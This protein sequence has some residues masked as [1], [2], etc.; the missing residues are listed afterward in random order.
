M[1]FITGAKV[2]AQN[3][4]RMEVRRRVCIGSWVTN[5]DGSLVLACQTQDVSARGVRVHPKETQP[6][7]KTVFYLDMQHRIAYEAIVRWQEKTEAGLEFTKAYRFT[8]MPSA[9]LK[10]VVQSLT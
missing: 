8:D 2:K 6:L 9:E 5:L 4:Q 3:D 1:P 7:P 10:K